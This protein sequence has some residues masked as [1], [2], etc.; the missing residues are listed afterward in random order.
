MQSQKSSTST[1]KSFFSL[2]MLLALVFIGTTAFKNTGEES[3]LSSSKIGSLTEDIRKN[4]VLAWQL[5]H[6]Y[7]HYGPG[8]MVRADPK[9]PQFLILASNRTFVA[10]DVNEKREGRW[11][12]DYKENTIVFFCDEINGERVEDPLTYQFVVRDYSSSSLKLAWQGRHGLVDMI[13]TPVNRSMKGSANFS[14]L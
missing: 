7:D 8:S 13:Y 14:S 10:F 1:F 11:E 6:N 4:E 12:V 5:N 2:F 3:P 9:N